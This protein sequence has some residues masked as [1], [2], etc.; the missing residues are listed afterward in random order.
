[1]KV[2]LIEAMKNVSFAVTVT[3]KRTLRGRLG[4]WLLQ[5]S[6]KLRVADELC[7]RGEMPIKVRLNE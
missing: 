3:F 1:M 6:T 5:W 2:R 4:F 7:D